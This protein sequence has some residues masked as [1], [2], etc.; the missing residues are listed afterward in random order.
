[1][2][3]WAYDPAYKCAYII[4]RN[5]EDQYQI[6]TVEDN[7]PIGWIDKSAVVLLPNP[8]ETIQASGDAYKVTAVNNK[9]IY[10]G[11]NTGS[12]SFESFVKYKWKILNLD[13]NEN[14]LQRKESD[15]TERRDEERRGIRY[16][17]NKFTIKVGHLSNQAR[18]KK[19]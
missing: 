2:N 3:R 7:R 19:S 4:L 16:R 9:G 6:G 17:R 5:F 8:G 10:F 11:D 12:L 18:S 14:Q 13:K 15:R 1:M